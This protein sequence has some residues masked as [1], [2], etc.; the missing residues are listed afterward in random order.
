MAYAFNGIAKT[1]TITS[2]TVMSV[3]DVYSRWLDWINTSDNS[4][5][6]PAF[7]T[8]GGNDIDSS[9]GTTVPIYAF[10]LN[11]WK[12]KPQELNHTLTVNDGILLVSGGGD[13]FINTDGNFIVRI[14]YQQPVQAITVATGGSGSIDYAAIAA[15]VWNHTQ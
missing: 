11:G 15:A 10:L 14:N 3:R 13:P 1:I 5:Y 9:A 6:L 2:Q 8:L 4:K 7:S 12:I